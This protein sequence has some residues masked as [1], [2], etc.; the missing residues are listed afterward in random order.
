MP[1]MIVNGVEAE[2][3]LGNTAGTL[4]DFTGAILGTD[5][6]SHNRT[7]LPQQIVGGRGLIGVRSTKFESH[8]F[9]LSTDANDTTEGVLRLAAANRRFFSIKIKDSDTALTGEGVVNQWSKTWDLNND[10]V[11]YVIGVNVDGLPS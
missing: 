7:N 5:S 8:D 4:Q 2:F 10:S 1:D 11:R 3:Q 6:I 9:L